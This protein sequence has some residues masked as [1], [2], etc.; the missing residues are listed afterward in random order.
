VRHPERPRQ[1]PLERR[2]L[3]RPAGGGRARAGKSADCEEGYEE[4]AA[5]V[6][7]IFGT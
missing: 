6:E 5:H 7:C 3:G 2:L 1:A 4:S